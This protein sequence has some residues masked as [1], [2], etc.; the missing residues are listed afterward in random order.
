M[1]TNLYSVRD[2]KLQKYG[3]PFVAPNDE[4]AKRMLHSTISA[5]GTTMS[6]FPEDFQLYKLGNYD[7]DT[8]EFE[9]EN[10]F[11]ANATEYKNEDKEKK[12]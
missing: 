8:G 4:I 7:D 5:G 6:E 11:L 3:I 10:E 9:T 12:E 2:I 1:K